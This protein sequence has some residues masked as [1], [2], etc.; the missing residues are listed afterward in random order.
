[1]TEEGRDYYESVYLITGILNSARDSRAL[2][3]S[4]VES[5]ARAM[6]QRPA[7]SCC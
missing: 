1:M 7:R 6:G 4:I 2:L 5:V 3:R